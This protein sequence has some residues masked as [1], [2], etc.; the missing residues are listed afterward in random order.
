MEVFKKYIDTNSAHLIVKILG[1]KLKFKTETAKLRYELNT[2]YKLINHTIDITNI[3]PAKGKLRE[4]QLNSANI[5]FLFDNIC[6]QNNIQ[7]WLNYGTLLGA[8]R[9]KGFI[10]W[11]DDIDVSILREDYNKLLPIL[12]KEFENNSDFQISENLPNSNVFFIK[13][14]RNISRGGG[15]VDIFIIDKFYT[16]EFTEKSEKSLI[17]TL[18]NAR[19]YF[20]KKHKMKNYTEEEINKI[21]KD[22][23]NIEQRY[24]LRNNGTE[25]DKVILYSSIGSSHD[26]EHSYF[27][28]ND[29][30]PLRR[31]EFE[32]NSYPVP[33]NYTK[34]LEKLF[35]DYMSFPPLNSIL[36]HQ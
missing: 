4:L 36:N 6:K 32:G 19:K 17:K 22:I 2:L 30:F 11:D 18:F 10:P 1:I 3:P 21:N 27:N 14:E 24:G 35:G 12:K 7:Y 8:V 9:H 26:W 15:C 23:L 34:Y 28:Y 29:I 20:E 31:L 33:N 13:L 5:L 16:E 25:K